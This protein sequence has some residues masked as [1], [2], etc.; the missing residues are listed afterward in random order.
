VRRELD[1]RAKLRLA[2]HCL[3]M[4]CVNYEGELEA[5]RD[6]KEDLERDLTD[7]RA[8]KL[9][10]ERE[11]KTA[12]ERVRALESDGIEKDRGMALIR[13]AFDEV[14]IT[15]GNLIE[16]VKALAAE[17]DQ[18]RLAVQQHAAATN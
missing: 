12:Q 9:N 17:R 10:V 3:D 13:A 14:G 18:Y 16:R 1:Y 2:G 11:L 6:E 15:D 8:A 7:V 5:L 4:T